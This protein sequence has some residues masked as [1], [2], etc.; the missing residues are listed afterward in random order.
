[1]VRQYTDPMTQ[2]DYPQ[3][4]RLEPA[5]IARALPPRRRDAHKG[6]YGSVLVI[7]GGQG[8]P[9]AVRLAGESALRVGAG[10]VTVASLPQHL[11]AVVGARPEL[12]FINAD[13]PNALA[14]AL[15]HADVVAIGP[16]LGTDAWAQS[17]LQAV[18]S[19]S[20]PAQQWVLDADALNLLAAMPAPVARDNWILTPHPGEAAR[21]LG[22][23]TA[24]VQADR[25]AAVGALQQ[26]WGGVVVLKGAGTLIG[27][28]G[29][30]TSL[31]DRG[32]PGMAIPGMGDVLTGAVAGILAQC[33]QPLLAAK[34]AVLAH[35]MAGDL[36]ATDGVRGL[37]A[38]DIARALHAVVNP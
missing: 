10:R 31:C 20:Q 32:N 38:G 14:A 30:V 4:Q 19:Q 36:C 7:G 34:A 1:M 24:A 29:Q 16:G 12:M 22:T 18:L 3:L 33:G 6:S 28:A 15:A 9:G 11:T 27:A 37:L 25:L 23:T 13:D 35:A 8:M 21:L 26:R 2:P 5:D 17:L